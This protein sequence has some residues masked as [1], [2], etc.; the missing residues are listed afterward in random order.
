MKASAW[1]YY[2]VMLITALVAGAVFAVLLFK[3]SN[4]IE[5]DINRVEEQN[6]LHWVSTCS[7]ARHWQD[8]MVDLFPNEDRTLPEMKRVC[9]KYG[10]TL[11]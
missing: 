3:Y 6:R 7:T 4:Q 8:L 2:K 10:V 1:R 11:D 5:S 9:G